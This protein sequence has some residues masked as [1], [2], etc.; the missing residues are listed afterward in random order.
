MLAGLR[1]LPTLEQLVPPPGAQPS[2]SAGVRPSAADPTLQRIRGLLAKAESTEFEAEAT[3]LTAKAQELMTRHAIDQAM[4][5][6]AAG[7]EKP[8]MFRIGIDAPYADAKSWLLQV[9][10]EAS[11]CRSVFMPQ[12]TMSTVVGDAT[13]VAGV[14]LLYTSLLVQAQAALGEAARHARPGARTRSKAYRSSF[15]LGFSHRIQERLE[16]AN[17]HVFDAAAGESGRFLPVLRARSEAL[18]DFMTQ[19]FQ[20]RAGPVRGGYDGA[21]WVGGE[22]AGDV[23]PLRAGDLVAGPDRP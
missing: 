11:R 6:G 16:E 18:E 14:E 13:D 15:L 20:L 19:R 12:V 4:L 21:G 10:A 17:R 3:A 9:I 5:Q 22:L 1:D 2:P 8:S 23:A 7:A